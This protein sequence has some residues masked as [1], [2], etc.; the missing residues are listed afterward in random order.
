MC[1]GAEDALTPVGPQSGLG[2]YSYLLFLSS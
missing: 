2:D 1:G